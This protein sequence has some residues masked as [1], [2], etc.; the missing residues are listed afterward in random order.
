[1]LWIL[2]LAFRQRSGPAGIAEV[3]ARPEM[4]YLPPHRLDT[5]R[6]DNMFA[7][8][9]RLPA[10][11]GA[12]RL[13]AVRRFVGHLH[14]AG[15]R[16]QAGT[17]ADV[18]GSVPGFAIHEELRRLV[19]AGLTPREALRVAIAAPAEYLAEVLSDL[20]PFGTIVVGGR[21][22]LILLDADPLEDV[23]HLE[24]PAGVMARGTWFPASDLRA[25]LDAAAR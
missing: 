3:V 4:R 20:E 17:D 1:T 15:A 14:D 2:E 6:D 8:F 16:I 7:A 25:M 12:I 22:D 19:E 23:A 5:W 24:E 9:P 10:A 18:A 13:E 11:E 21:A